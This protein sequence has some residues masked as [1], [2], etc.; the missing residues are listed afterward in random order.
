MRAPLF[1][2]LFFVAEML[3]KLPACEVQLP[4]LREG[5]RVGGVEGFGA[6]LQI[7]RFREFEVLQDRRIQIG[8]MRSAYLL[9]AAAKRGIIRSARWW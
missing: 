7:R 1:S 9:D 6:E 3:L 4:R 8:E 2:L 5:R